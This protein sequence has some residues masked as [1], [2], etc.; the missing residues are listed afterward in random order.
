MSVLWIRIKLFT[1][2]RIQ[3]W[4]QLFTSNRIRIQEA[5]L[6]RIHTNPD[7]DH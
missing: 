6:M 3:I 7:P 5:K 4:I 1:S 2:M